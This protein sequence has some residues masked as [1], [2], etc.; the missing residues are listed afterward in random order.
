LGTLTGTLL[1][2]GAGAHRGLLD[3]AASDQ[4]RRWHERIRDLRRDPVL[5]LAAC[6]RFEDL[7]PVAELLSD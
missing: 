3:H 5:G 7:R 6:A 4:P 1:A 2:G